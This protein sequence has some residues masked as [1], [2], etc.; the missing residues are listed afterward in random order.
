M[1][2]TA[3]KSLADFNKD[4]FNKKIIFILNHQ[5]MKPSMTK[6]SGKGGGVQFP[7]SFTIPTECQIFDKHSQRQRIIRYCLGES[8]IF[9]DEQSDDKDVPKKKQRIEFSNGLLYV[10][11][12]QTQL[13]EY[14]RLC[15]YNGTNKNRTSEAKPFF[16]E[17]N[18]ESGADKL[19]EKEKQTKKAT[20]WCLDEKTDFEELKAYAMVLNINIDKSANEIRFD[21]LNLAKKDPTKFLAGLNNAGTK[22]K[23][24]I[25]DAINNNILTK[26][27]KGNTISWTGGNVICTA[28]IGIDPIDHL[29]GLTFSDERGEDLFQ[30][31]KDLNSPKITGAPVTEE[32]KLQFD[33]KD[34]EALVAQGLAA[35]VLTKNGPWI[36]LDKDNYWQG[37]GAAV[38]ISNNIVLKETIKAAIAAKVPNPV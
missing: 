13:L 25:L 38:A 24:F 4:Q 27:T 36:R 7:N 9:K 15:E 10:E 22:R 37:K 16:L 19:L 8:S 30:A 14:L 2:T 28:P 31:I 12:E 1:A 11:K 32:H 3:V 21:L 23:Y 29:V 18:A 26:N 17:Y 35:G 33:I 5:N 20:D 34:A 6:D